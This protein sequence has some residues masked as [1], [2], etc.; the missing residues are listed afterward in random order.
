MDVA[1]DM[2]VV[3]KGSSRDDRNDR[4]FLEGVLRRFG[5]AGMSE[6]KAYVLR[7]EIVKEVGD[8]GHRDGDNKFRG[9]VMGTLQQLLFCYKS[10]DIGYIHL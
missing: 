9:F 5:T 2:A 3:K 8:E 6:K 7:R 1:M 4:K 10:V